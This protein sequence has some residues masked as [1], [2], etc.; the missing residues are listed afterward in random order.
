[1]SWKPDQSNSLQAQIVDDK[2]KQDINH[3]DHKT[4]LSRI[5]FD[6]FLPRPK[7]AADVTKRTHRMLPQQDSVDKKNMDRYL[8]VRDEDNELLTPSFMDPHRILFLN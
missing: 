6:K 1:M 7:A 2:E 4:L 8:C 5:R 3:P